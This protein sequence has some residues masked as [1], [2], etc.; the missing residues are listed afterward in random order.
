MEPAIIFTDEDYFDENLNGDVDTLAPQ[1]ELDFA[2][3]G[4]DP[5]VVFGATVNNLFR[6]ESIYHWSASTGK[7]VPIATTDL[8]SLRGITQHPQLLFQPGGTMG[9]SYPTIAVGDDGQ[10]IV[11][12]YMA[13]GQMNIDPNPPLI[14]SETGFGYLRI[15][16]VGSTDGGE[17][18]GANRVLHNWAGD[19]GIDSASVEYP[20][21]DE[22]CRVDPETGTVSID[23]AFQARR[24]PGMYAFIVN[25]VNG[26][27]TPANRGPIEECFQ[28]H[29]RTALSPDMFQ[30]SL[31]VED[32][33]G[34]TRNYD[35]KIKCYPNPAS[36]SASI[37]FTTPRNGLVTVKIYDALGR[38]VMTVVDNE[39]LYAASHL[40]EVELSDLPAGTYRVVVSQGDASSSQSLNVVH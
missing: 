16:M 29:Q 17:T 22:T 2:Y 8:D 38:A 20:S 19:E 9:L 36:N 6:F 1:S 26:T 12:A 5:H 18:W 4:E 15:W 33:N 3:M 40:R 10:H 34:F 14:A 39:R 21:L 30:S 32:D 7:V 24:N 37:L 31:S 28:Y 11:V 27:G 13:Q 23:L 25:D 35:A